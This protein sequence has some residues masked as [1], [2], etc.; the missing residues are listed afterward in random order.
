MKQ[1]LNDTSS[2]TK[3]GT[4]L[5]CFRSAASL[6][7]PPPELPSFK[8]GPGRK[9]GVPGAGCWSENGKKIP[10]RGS[11]E[12]LSSLLGDLKRR[13]SLEPAT[14]PGAC[15][16]REPVQDG[17]TWGHRAVW[18]GAGLWRHQ[19]SLSTKLRFGFFPENQEQNLNLFSLFLKTFSSILA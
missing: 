12:A 18:G 4:G 19:Q 10:S 16:G 13:R 17:R 7:A 15:L 3:L 5:P 11:Q 14:C 9:A 6:S 2:C 8:A 1:D